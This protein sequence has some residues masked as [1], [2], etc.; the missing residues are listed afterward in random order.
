MITG[1][2]RIKRQKNGNIHHYTYYHCTK[3]SK[4]IKCDEPHIREEELDRQLSSLIKQHTLPT[5][6][7]EYFTNRLNEDKKDSAQSVSLYVAKTKKQIM[8]INLKLQRLLDGYLDQVIDQDIYRQE[9]SKLMSRKESL[10]ENIHDLQHRENHWLEPMTEWISKAS[11]LPKVAECGDLTDKK[12]AAIDIYG[13]NLLLT[14]RQARGQARDHW[15]MVASA[16]K[17]SKSSKNLG[18][19]TKLESLYDSVRTYFMRKS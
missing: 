16:S 12:V 11:T 10:T 19:S 4:S 14:A 5:E 18:K 8:D 6:W 1:E 17:Q 7:A 15:G 3:K 9:K 13:S 2:K